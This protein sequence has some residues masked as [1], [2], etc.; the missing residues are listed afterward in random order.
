MNTLL[1]LFLSGFLI[2]NVVLVKFLGM[3]P[4]LGVSKERG[5]SV[6]MGLVTTVV[7][8]L[9]SVLT[10]GLYYGILKPLDLTY[11]DLIVFILV[12]AGFVQLLEM[13]LKK[14]VPKLYETFGIYLPLITTNCIV[15]F[16]ALENIKQGYSF[17]EMCVYSLAVPLG[18]T[19][20]LFIF[21]AIRELKLNNKSIPASFKGNPISMIT[22][23]LIALVFSAIVLGG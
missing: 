20:V 13:V 5:S 16:V 7:I 11:L 10:Y 18:F 8:F 22:L 12:I 23:G 17:I 4:A 3:C 1:M 19:L 21:A 14:Y 2:D 15:L 6:G 9:S